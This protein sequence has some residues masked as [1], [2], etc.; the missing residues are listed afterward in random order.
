MPVNQNQL[1]FPEIQF[2]IYP[3][4]A[5]N[6]SLM[7]HQL[8]YFQKEYILTENTTTDIMIGL[9]TYYMSAHCQQIVL[10]QARLTSYHLNYNNTYSS[11]NAFKFKAKHKAV[12]PCYYNVRLDLQYCCKEIHITL[13]FPSQLQAPAPKGSLQESLQQNAVQAQHHPSTLQV[14]KKSF[15]HVKY[16]H[17]SLL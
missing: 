6:I 16:F 5:W 11:S 15:V 12:S 8:N 9:N 4:K 7:K 14:T 1:S 3:M 2:I 10:F 13:Q 17:M